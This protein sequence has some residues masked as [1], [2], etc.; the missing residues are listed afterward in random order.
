MNKLALLIVLSFYLGY[1]AYS[2]IKIA[3]TV[4]PADLG[5]HKWILSETAKKDEVA[6][7][8]SATI[9]ELKNGEKYVVTTTVVNY[10]PNKK[11]QEVIFAYAPSQF[12]FNYPAIPKWHIRVFGSMNNIKGRFA[13]C[14]TSTTDNSGS[15][16]FKKK[17]GLV[18]KI[19]FNSYILKISEA[20]KR[21]KK[22]PKFNPF[23]SWRWA[24]CNNYIEKSKLLKIN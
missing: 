18:V 14:F 9:T 6:I 23:T 11:T 3:D 20:K 15:I 21:Y 8:Q 19:K 2:G 24:D 7:F 5:A 17:D 4:T 12:D 13:G 10:S 16:E 22:L 1:N